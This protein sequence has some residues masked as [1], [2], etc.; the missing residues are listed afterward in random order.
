MLE[1]FGFDLATLSMFTQQLPDYKWFFFIITQ[2]GSPFTLTLLA[3]L[4]FVLGKSKMK[5]FSAI[6]IIGLIFSIVIVDDLKEL[7]QRPRPDGAKA[8][9]FLIMDSYSFPSGHATSIFLTASLLGAYFGWKLYAAGYAMAI[10]V[11]LSRLYLGVH[12]PSDIIAGALLGIIMGELAVYAAYRFGLCGSPGLVRIV[13]GWPA[14]TVHPGMVKPDLILSIAV[15]LGLL[16]AIVLYFMN[17][18]PLALFVLAAAA[19]FIIFYVAS[20]GRSY[21]SDRFTAFTILAIGIIAALSMLYIGVFLLSLIT[22]VVTYLA[23]IALK[24]GRKKV[25]TV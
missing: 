22:I 12:Y 2:L 24:I 7:A 15:F 3:S 16:M 20:S 19:I 17:Y 9:D 14:R 18:A 4:G 5:V 11:S 6:L 23:V 1:P 25:D 13:S 10:A 21:D 8:A